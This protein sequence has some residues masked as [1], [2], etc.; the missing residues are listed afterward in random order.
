M[1][2][3][4][5][6]LIFFL[7]VFSFTSKAQTTFKIE[8]F[9][10]LILATVTIADESINEVFKQGTIQVFDSKTKK[11]IINIESPEL[12]F[13]L[14]S[15]NNIKTNV[16]QLPYGEQ[17][18]LIYEDF[19]FDGNQ[20]L[21]V[22]FGQESCY[23]GPSY[24]IYLFDKGKFV[25]DDAFSA[26]A[27]ENCGMF[28]V[29]AKLKQ[30][31]TFTKS[32]CCWHLDT[33]YKIVN[34]N[35]IVIKTIEM[36]HQKYPFLYT[37]TT[38]F[39]KK[40]VAIIKKEIVFDQM[41]VK[42]LFSFRLLKNNKKVVLF[43][44]GEN[45]LYYALIRVNDSVEF[46]YPDDDKTENQTFIIDSISKNISFMNENTTYKIYLETTQNKTVSVGIIIT[47]ENESSNLV[48]D[49]STIKGDFKSIIDNKYNNVQ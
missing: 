39:G 3:N 11:E 46:N 6:I 7:L 2:N 28:Q 38:T 23:H 48:G 26:L 14:N 32:G 24:S 37:T 40:K 15:K 31:N 43:D 20:D 21:A 30:L 18:I 36:N 47:N 45:N 5:R 33:T 12:T 29:N 1:K 25:Y 9:S 17:S 8:K 44:D 49:K 10:N 22:M 4:I 16:K 41:A 19:N 27:T 42:E 35:P 34:N 13:D